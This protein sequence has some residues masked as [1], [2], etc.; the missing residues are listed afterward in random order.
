MKDLYR[1]SRGLLEAALPQLPS[2]LVEGLF[3]RYFPHHLRVV[4]DG[5]RVAAMLFSIPYAVEM[6]QGILPARYLFAIVTDPAYR[7]RGLAK[8]LIEDEIK[9]GF[10]LLLHP[11]TQSLFA[12]Y[13][14]AGLFPLSPVITEEG[15]AVALPLPTE[16][17]TLSAGEYLALRRQFLTPPFGVPDEAFLS[18]CSAGAL[19]LPGVC[20]AL[21]RWEG[22]KLLFAEWLGNPDFAPRLAA[23]LGAA[24]F[25]LR[26]P[27]PDGAPFGV[28][29]GLPFDTAFLLSLM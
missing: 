24:R 12:F 9:R 1:E 29:V 4:A 21:Y 14:K 7:G 27:S 5:G 20:A 26:R 16:P 15:E 8:G 25:A 23:Y 11:R 28:G 6:P 3:A 19:E 13:E 18:L 17:R 2:A 22:D 10:P